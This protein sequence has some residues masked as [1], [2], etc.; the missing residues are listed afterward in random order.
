[1][2]AEPAFQAAEVF[3][4]EMLVSTAFFSLLAAVSVRDI[5]YREV[6]GRDCDD[7]MPEGV[8]FECFPVLYSGRIHFSAVFGCGIMRKRGKRDWRRGY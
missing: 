6:S 5:W 4:M 2:Q 3:W 8:I 1:M 7:G